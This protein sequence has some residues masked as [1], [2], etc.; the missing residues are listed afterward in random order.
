MTTCPV[1]CIIIDDPVVN[2]HD[3][4]CRSCGRTWY[5]TGMDDA[6]IASRPRKARLTKLPEAG[7]KLSDIVKPIQRPEQPEERT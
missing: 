2:G 1:C 6:P 7:D 3:V 5:A 4:Q